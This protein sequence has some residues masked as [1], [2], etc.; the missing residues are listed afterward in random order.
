MKE[1][2]GC[3]D[4]AS[5]ELLVFEGH[6]HIF[7]IEGKGQGSQVHVEAD[8]QDAFFLELLAEWDPNRVTVVPKLP[9]AIVGEPKLIV[10]EG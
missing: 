3:V 5:S 6:S 7:S 8:S 1:R 2:D 10:R 4:R 9:Q